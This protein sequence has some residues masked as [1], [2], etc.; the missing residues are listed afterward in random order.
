MHTK[1]KTEKRKVK[2]KWYHSGKDNE[3]IYK[4]LK[5]EITAKGKKSCTGPSKE[6][7]GRNQKDNRNA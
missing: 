2:E 7:R 1:F 5:R 3:F 6:E 4:P